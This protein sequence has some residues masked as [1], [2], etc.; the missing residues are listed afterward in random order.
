MMRRDLQSLACARGFNNLRT[1]CACDVSADVCVCM[2]RVGR[3]GASRAAA[4]GVDQVGGEGVA[5]AAGLSL[6]N[7]P[8]FPRRTGKGSR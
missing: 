6:V 8:G 2:R 5:V 3:V 7:A 4:A 1:L